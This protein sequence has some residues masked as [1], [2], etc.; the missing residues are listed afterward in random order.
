MKRIIELNDVENVI[1]NELYRSP[2]YSA[3]LNYNDPIVQGLLA[4]N[5]IYFGSKQIVTCDYNNNVPIRITL[6]PF[7]YQCLNYY[8]PKLEQKIRKLKLKSKLIK[9]KSKTEKMQKE[10]NNMQEN[11]NFYFC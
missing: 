11:Y 3:W 4:R 1:I 7:V 6:Q 2:G 5:Y 10:I 9:N 8:K